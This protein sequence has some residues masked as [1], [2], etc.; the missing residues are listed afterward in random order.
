MGDPGCCNE[1]LRIVK[2]VGTAGSNCATLLIY[3]SIEVTMLFAE[4]L[5]QNAYFLR[6]V[7]KVFGDRNSVPIE[8]IIDITESFRIRTLIVE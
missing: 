7:H 4:L 6:I 5:S 2:K 1:E 3:A 8:T